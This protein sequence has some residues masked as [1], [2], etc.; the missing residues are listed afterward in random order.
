MTENCPVLFGVVVILPEEV[1]KLD[2]YPCE[3]NRCPAGDST[4]ISPEFDTG[5]I[6]FALFRCLSICD[7]IDA[8]V[9]TDNSLLFPALIK[10]SQTRGVPLEQRSLVWGLRTLK[11]KSKSKAFL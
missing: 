8:N 1:R 4:G 11:C 6:H 10:R 3:D 9:T 2:K 5:P 7:H